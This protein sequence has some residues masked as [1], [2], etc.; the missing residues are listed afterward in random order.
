MSMNSRMDT[1]SV[2]YS[3]NWMFFN[4]DNELTTAICSMD[5]T[6]KHNIEPKKARHKKA[7]MM[8]QR[9]I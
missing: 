9:C 3:T 6:H 4:D 7:R 5:E 2:D 1:L 8:C